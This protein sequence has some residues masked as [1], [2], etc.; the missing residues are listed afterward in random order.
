[1]FEH[2]VKIEEHIPGEGAEFKWYA[3]GVGVVR[4]TPAT[5]DELLISHTTK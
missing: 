2:C 1:M 3:P 4:E 5:G